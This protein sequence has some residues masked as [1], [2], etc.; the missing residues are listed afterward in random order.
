[1][2]DVTLVTGGAAS[3][4]DLT[5][6]DYHEIYT[7][8]REKTNLRQFAQ[9]A[10]VYSFA[11]WSQF[12]RYEKPCTWPARAALRKMVGLPALPL[13]VDVAL[14]DAVDGD[15]EIYRIGQTGHAR[16]VLLLTT[17]EAVTVHWNGRG[18]HLVDDAQAPAPADVTGV[19]APKEHRRY[20]RPSLPDGWRQRAELAGVDVRA[21]V[22]AAI[23]KAEA[24]HAGY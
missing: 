12:E 16:R 23:E 9:E 5:E 22:L 17:N 2:D 21:S 13:P 14:A 10:G 20:W 18:P 19:T 6:T 15:A 8:I 7:E 1:M 3:A 24:D 4:D 11:W